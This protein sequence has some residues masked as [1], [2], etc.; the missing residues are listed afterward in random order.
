MEEIVDREIDPQGSGKEGEKNRQESWTAVSLSFFLSC[1]KIGLIAR[2]TTTTT[3]TTTTPVRKSKVKK[4]CAQSPG[5]SWG[6]G[7]SDEHDEG[8]DR[9]R[10]RKQKR[11]EN[12]KKHTL[13]ASAER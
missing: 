12:R 6:R 3:M 10:R 8:D 13:L 11:K 1:H 7:E 5:E 2:V 4:Y 9:E